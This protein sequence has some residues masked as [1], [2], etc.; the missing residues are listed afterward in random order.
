MQIRISPGAVL[1]LFVMAL[2]QGSLFP[3]VLLAVTA[4]ECGHLLASRLLGV[5]L[6]ALELDLPG[7]RL[8]PAGLLPSYRA[9]ALLA[10][11]GPAASLLLAA[12]TLPHATP[13]A[14][15][16]SAVTLSLFLFNLLP[17]TEFDGGR[18][19]FCLIAPRFGENA[20]RRTLLFCS[21]LSLLSLFSLSA[22]LLLRYGESM[23]LAVLCATFFAKL[24]L[25]DKA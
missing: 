7:A 16:L 6:R 11:A 23:M 10:A 13:F 17:I 15:T 21:Y 19:L 2:S 9:E 25:T 12:F 3:A 1:L 22:C 8:I 20:A 14:V 24:F 18:L 5:R 4:H